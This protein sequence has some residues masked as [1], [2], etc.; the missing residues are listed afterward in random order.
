MRSVEIFKNKDPPI[1]T[2]EE[3]SDNVKELDKISKIL[4]EDKKYADVS[5]V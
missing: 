2:I 1:L 5:S 3:M 4:A